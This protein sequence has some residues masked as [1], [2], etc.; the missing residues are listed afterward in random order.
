M[1]ETY[2]PELNMMQKKISAKLLQVEQDSLPQQ[3]KSARLEKMKLF[4]TM[5]ER[6]LAFLTISKAAIVPA[7]KDKLSSY[8]EQIRKFRIANRP[9]KLVSALHQGQLLPTHMHSMQQPQPESN[10]TQSHDNEMNPQFPSMMR[11]AQM[12]ELKKQMPRQLLQMLQQRGLH[13]VDEQQ[14]PAK[15]KTNELSFWHEIDID[16]GVQGNLPSNQLPGYKEA[17]SEYHAP[18]TAG[19]GVPPTM[20]IPPLLPGFKEVNDTSGNALTTDFGKPDITE[21]PHDL[22]VNMAKPK[23]LSATVVTM[24]DEAVSAVGEDLAAM[25]KQ[26][27]HARNFFTQTGM[28]G[29]EKMRCYLSALVILALLIF[30]IF[31]LNHQ[32]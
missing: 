1:K 21:Q 23:S 27:L 26:G 13:R 22:K 2:F 31:N 10:Q 19:I 8:E 6:I 15:I 9:M 14:S 17:R 3:P 28:S 16:S 12:P 7:F 4:K 24:V 30:F 5:L 29:A 18:D 11:P 32:Y 20:S 25:K